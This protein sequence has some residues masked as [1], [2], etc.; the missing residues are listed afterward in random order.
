MKR[1]E[2]YLFQ[3]FILELLL[4]EQSRQALCWK[5]GHLSDLV[6][7]KFYRRKQ[8]KH[9]PFFNFI[10]IQKV[11]VASIISPKPRQKKFFLSRQYQANFSN[12]V[13]HQKMLLFVSRD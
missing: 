12:F 9:F 2:K 11:P 5:F 3:T 1:K 10:I 6:D 8:K 4:L 7:W 13:Y